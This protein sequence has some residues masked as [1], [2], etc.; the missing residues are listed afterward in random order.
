[1]SF[2]LC[3]NDKLMLAHAPPCRSHRPAQIKQL[4]DAAFEA[5]EPFAIGY[6]ASFQAAE[7]GNPPY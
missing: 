4:L 5:A 1:M 7:L 2:C 3:F 6:S